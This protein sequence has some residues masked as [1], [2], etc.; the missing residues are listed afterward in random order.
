M[1]LSDSLNMFV[2]GSVLYGVTAFVSA[3]L[4]SYITA[5]RGRWS[6]GRAITLIAAAYNIGAFAGPLL[7]GWLG[8]TAGL[9]TNFMATAV[10]LLAPPP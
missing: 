1:A 7:G 6:V 10:T 9:H 5:A 3:P 4:N 2:M 8:E